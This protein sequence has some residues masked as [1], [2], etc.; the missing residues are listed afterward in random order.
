MAV[1]EAKL[2]TERGKTVLNE[3][4]TPM[5]FILVNKSRLKKV[6]D[7]NKEQGEKWEGTF[8]PENALKCEGRV[9]AYSNILSGKT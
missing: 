6:I 7:W 5:L 9:E 4:G 8:E 2:V 3:D 1:I